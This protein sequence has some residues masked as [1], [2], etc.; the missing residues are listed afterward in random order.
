MSDIKEIKKQMI[1][2]AHEM[3]VIDPEQV[4]RLAH[5]GHIIKLC[6]DHDRLTAELEAQSIAHNAYKEANRKQHVRVVELTTQLAAANKKIDDAYKWLIK[7]LEAI[8]TDA[9]W[10]LKTILTEQGGPNDTL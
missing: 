1:E 6:Q 7:H 3:E 10:E 9:F 4:G 2:E 5:W 8:P